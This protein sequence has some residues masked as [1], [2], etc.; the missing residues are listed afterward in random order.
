MLGQSNKKESV[1]RRRCGRVD[2]DPPVFSSTRRPNGTVRPVLTGA[3]AMLVCLAG[4]ASRADL[5]PALPSL[6]PPYAQAADGKRVYVV[7][8]RAPAAL[9]IHGAMR[10]SAHD[11]S[12]IAAAAPALQ[13]F[14]EG[15][16]R[17]HDELLAT[18]GASSEKIYSYRYALNGF[19][20]RLSPIQVSKLRGRP[21][22]ARVTED[23]LRHLKTNDSPGF[24]GLLARDAGLRSGLGLQG[25]DVVIGIIDSGIAAHHPSFADTVD[26]PMPRLCQTRWGRHSLLG[27]WLCRRF[28][29]K[30]PTVAFEAPTDWHG[31]CQ[32]GPGF[33]ASNCNNK[34]IGARFYRSGFQQLYALDQ[35]EFPSPRDADGHGTHIASV[36]AG[37]GVAATIGGADL[38]R[39]SGMAPRARVA[40]YK[41]CWLEPGAIR[42]SCAMSD[43]A[44]AIDDAVADGVDII[45]YAVGAADGLP[46]D[47]DSLA[48]LAASNA[49]VLPVAAAGN[50]GPNPSTLESPGTAPWTLTVGAASRAGTRFDEAIKITAPTQIAG[51]YRAKEAGFTRRL[52]TTGPVST[53]LILVNDGVLAIS[54]SSI[55]TTYDGCEAIQ[56][57]VA[58]SG[59]VA[60]LQR[61]ICTFQVKLHNAEAAGAKAAIV[62]SDA[63]DLILMDGTRGSVNIPAVMIGKTDGARILERLQAG[64][65]VN[66]TLDKSIVLTHH[67]GGNVMGKFSARGPNLAIADV[68]KPEVVAPGV[69]ILGAQTPDVANGVR[70]ETFQYLSGTSMAVP[71]VAGIAALLKE[72]HPDWSPAAL[73]SA[74][75]TTARQDVLEEDGKTAA[76]PF[77]FGGGYIV[78]NKA[79]SPGLLYEAGQ[80]DYDAYSCGT[81]LPL[82][83][84]DDCAALQAA[85][86][87]F[88]AAELNLP[89]IAVSSFAGATSVRRR[90]TNADA[91]ATYTAVITQPQ[92]TAITVSP[93][94]LSL[95]AGA[96]ADY[97]VTLT[98]LGTQTDEWQFGSLTW[99][100]AG[101]AVRSPLAVMARSLLGPGDV[102]GT[103]ITGAVAIPL[104]FGY[105]GIYQ[106]AVLPLQGP[107]PAGIAQDIY[108]AN[109][110][111]ASYAIGLATAD[112]PASVTRRVFTVAPGVTLLRVALYDTDTDG[113]GTDNLDLYVYCPGGQCS[114]ANAVLASTNPTSNESID[115]AYPEAGDYV[116]DVHGFATDEVAGGT[117]AKFKLFAWA[118]DG[119]GTAD[120]AVAGP[121]AVAPGQNENVAVSWHDLVPAARYLGVVIHSDGT[122]NLGFTAVSVAAP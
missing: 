90:V 8:L 93:A 58:L 94:S 50:S 117:G 81:A 57:G 115:I 6:V 79:I 121:E 99:T 19:A 61:G 44:Q 45:N 105:A 98:N 2:P 118:I 49:G 80:P 114:Q 4:P 73:R 17:S 36:A 86:Y 12:R 92:G 67:D 40:V 22:V 35:N 77:D 110:P 116:I 27:R 54:G 24:L 31:V 10:R 72:S 20:A 84:A 122:R 87:S 18:V 15:L 66:V 106:P 78:P 1:D 65:A 42:G 89:T 100:S 113:H 23:R 32:T 74:L 46:T 111:S 21:D 39:V 34:L 5:Q 76:D 88:S 48:L 3:L 63:D 59:K 52:R 16:A 96:S 37:V 112:L 64:A 13:A 91:A 83:S 75:V 7:Q 120:L 103:G 107:D 101:H 55:G 47:P 29:S 38:A 95:A 104:Q 69:D 26:P 11:G 85:G 68:L 60:F 71:H 70:G 62:F 109:D 82:V 108:V 102:A 14:G 9:A 30:A 97:T 41:A 28:R 43:L 56:N 25:E 51:S 119:S 53:Q 33:D